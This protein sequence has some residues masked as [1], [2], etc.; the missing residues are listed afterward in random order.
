MSSLDEI[1]LTWHPAEV[2]IST[3]NPDGLPHAA[4]VGVRKVGE[5][6][7]GVKVFTD[8]HTFRNLEKWKGATI[9]LTEDAKLLVRI[10]LKK[11]LGFSENQL[12]FARS[13]MVNAP[14]V[15][16]LPAYADLEVKEITKEKLSDELGE[17]EI[18]YITLTVKK[19]EVAKP[20]V[21]PFKRSDF[22]LIE[23]AVLA[24]KVMKAIEGGKT[25]EAKRRLGK[26]EEYKRLCDH[27]A[28]SSEES[29]IIAEIAESLKA[30]MNQVT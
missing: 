28:P 23:S 12:K 16:G 26:I 3:F 9:N 6:E 21:R 4:V 2:I 5:L 22:F 11:L 15:I 18:A 10:A 17:S 25:E 14:R 19:I 13:K 7:V 1:G 30:M 29:A 20:F 24:T 8:T 27:I